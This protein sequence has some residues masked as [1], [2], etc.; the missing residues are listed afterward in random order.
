MA[1]LGQSPPLGGDEDRGHSL[2]VVGSI[3]ATIAT[4]TILSRLLA[5]AIVVKDL[6][7]DDL[8]ISLGAVSVCSFVRS[9]L[10]LTDLSHGRYL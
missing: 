3:F 5:R 8:F 4:V 10:R 9:H 2:L 1:N 7:L 6:G